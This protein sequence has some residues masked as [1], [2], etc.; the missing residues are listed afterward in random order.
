M[1]RRF[2]GSFDALTKMG[3]V[4]QN[5]QRFKPLGGEGKPLWEFKEFDHRIF[6]C[7]IVTGQYVEVVLFN[8]WIK[9][10]DDRSGREERSRIQNAQHLYQEYLTE[11]GK[12][13]S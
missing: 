6:C 7:R 10:K 11:E 8:G 4:Y 3:A 1:S 9:D 2:Q 13:E 5:S 12:V